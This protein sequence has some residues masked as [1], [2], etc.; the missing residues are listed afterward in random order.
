MNGGKHATWAKQY[1]DK[2]TI[3]LERGIKS[4]EKQIELH[5]DKI[6]NPQKHYP[7]WE[8]EDFRAREHW[9]NQKWPGDIARQQEQKAILEG[10]LKGKKE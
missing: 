3:E 7:N 1:I 4:L 10:I 8:K 5:K 9:V 2:P 6:I